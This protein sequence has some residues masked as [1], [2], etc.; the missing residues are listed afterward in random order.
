M[1]PVGKINTYNVKSND[2]YNQIKPNPIPSLPLHPS[3]ILH[4]FKASP[5]IAMTISTKDV[6]IGV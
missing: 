3:P 2:V 5:P 6:T 1:I 4:P